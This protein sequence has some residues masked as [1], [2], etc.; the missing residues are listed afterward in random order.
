MK[1][2][3]ALVMTVM[4]CVSFCACNKQDADNT[5]GGSDH[6]VDVVKLASSGRIPDVNFMLGDSVTAVKDELF[7]ISAGMT[8]D[9]FCENMRDAGYEPDGKEYDG[10]VTETKSGDHVIMASLYNEENAGSVYC[11]YTDGHEKSGISA[12]AV[13]GE[14][15]G[16]DGNTIIEYVKNAVDAEFT[17]EKADSNFYFL[18]KGEG[19]VCLTYELG[20]HKLELYF[21]EYR[22]FVAAV[23]YDMN[24]W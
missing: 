24:I 23:I 11:M 18:P 13:V 12:I 1:R 19:A 15:Y 21:S 3:T 22:T 10:Y 5:Y 6:E 4:I 14:A 2:F 16:F 7:S 17:E 8:H 9:E 20:S